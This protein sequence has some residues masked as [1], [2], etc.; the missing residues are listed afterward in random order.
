ML[1]DVI[2][3]LASEACDVHPAV[4]YFPNNEWYLTEETTPVHHTHNRRS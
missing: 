4:N 1:K 3:C 2:G